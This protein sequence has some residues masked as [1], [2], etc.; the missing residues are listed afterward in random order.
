MC[1]SVTTDMPALFPC[2]RSSDKLR[3]SHFLSISLRLLCYG[4]SIG[5]RSL[6][7]GIG[8]LGVR[9]VGVSVA[10]FGRSSSVVVG[11]SALGYWAV[12]WAVLWIL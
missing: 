3:Y 12:G 7:V 6:F 11:H 5:S 9:G 10:H 1:H 4:F 8:L 2:C